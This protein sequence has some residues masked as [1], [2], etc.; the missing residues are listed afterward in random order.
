MASTSATLDDDAGRGGGLVIAGNRQLAFRRAARHSRLVAVLRWLLPAASLG[1][2]GVYGAEVVRVAGWGGKLQNLTV[3]KVDP[4]NLSMENPKYEGYN[5]D[6]G[7]YVV[8]ADTAKQELSSLGSFKLQ[9]IRGRLLQPD[10]S[11]TDLVAKSGTYD[12]KTAAIELLERIKVTGSNGLVAHL[13]QALIDTKQS[14]ITSTQPVEVDMPTATVKSRRMTLHNKQRQVT[15]VDQVRTHLIPAPKPAAS[16]DATKAPAAAAPTQP[17]L[18]GGGSGP[19]DIDS[20]RLDID[21]LKRTALFKGDVVAVQAESTLRTPEMLVTYESAEPP[22]GSDGKPEAK[23]AKQPMGQQ[24]SGRVDRIVAKG[25]V[26]MTRAGRDEV[27]SDA[28]EYDGR[29][30]IV[31]LTGNVVMTQQPDKRVTAARADYDSRGDTVLLTGG[32][33]VQAGRNELHGRRMFVDNK[34]SRTQL[35]SPAEP[36]HAAGRIAARFYRG[37][38]STAA[39]VAGAVAKAA[40]PADDNPMA[41]KFAT[42]PT[43][44]IDVASVTLDVDDRG[45]AAT[46]RGDVVANQGTLSVKSAEMIV[47]YSGSAG[48]AA[49]QQP[50]A[51][52]AAPAAPD[53]GGAQVTLIEARRKVVVS[54]TKDGQTATGDWANYDA[55]SNMIEL[56]GDVLLTQGQNV[57][58]GTRLHIDMATGE[59]RIATT[60]AEGWV[61]RAAKP[62][63]APKVALPTP[64]SPNTFR[65]DRPSAV[66][67]PKMLDKKAPADPAQAGAAQPGAQPGGP[68]AGTVGDAWSAATSTRPRN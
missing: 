59:S 67:Y 11:T 3:P 47:H 45:K 63:E 40:K 13:T 54:S 21:D 29:S 14:V 16:A 53:G 7:R 60:P 66:F 37:T 44:P 26:A 35:S 1:I 2:L 27:T 30:E 61:A 32:V 31:T 20:A 9:G 15:F 33:D 57:V 28:M 62:G 50:P 38:P 24:G 25:P 51:A 5:Q 41:G 49:G 64:G 68:A 52:G 8:V 65:P 55:K 22:P 43:A 46:F 36:G 6:G 12:S 56:G 34:A 4:L 23:P 19:V 10:G 18:L 48:V 42:D 58:R 17:A 39:Q